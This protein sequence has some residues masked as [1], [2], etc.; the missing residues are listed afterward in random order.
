MYATE[1]TFSVHWRV[2]GK[3]P[4]YKT[5]LTIQGVN[6]IIPTE[7]QVFL[8]NALH[9]NWYKLF[10]SLSKVNCAVIPRKLE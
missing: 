8:S 7:K 2:D 9:N 4:Y 1:T 6:E 5:L 10:K 3:Q